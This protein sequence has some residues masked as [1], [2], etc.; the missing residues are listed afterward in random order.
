MVL[1]K[2]TDPIPDISPG[3]SE[4]LRKIK[5]ACT[6]TCFL[7]VLLRKLPVLCSFWNNQTQQ[8][9]DSDFLFPQKEPGTASSLLQKDFKNQNKWLLRKLIPTQHCLEH[10][11]PMTPLLTPDPKPGTQDPWLL[12]QKTNWPAQLCSHWHYW[13]CGWGRETQRER[14]TDNFFGKCELINRETVCS[15]L[16]PNEKEPTLFLVLQKIRQPGLRNLHNWDPAL[17]AVTL[18]KKRKQKKILRRKSHYCIAQ[19]PKG[20]GE[21][22]FLL[23]YLCAENHS[24]YYGLN[25]SSYLD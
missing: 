20:E 12:P 18:S 13:P 3:F 2:L 21:I 1:K 23:P 8:F 11:D 14:A 24:Y 6:T 17:R 7:A 10:L 19:S 9:F 22:N 25:P 16:Q 15:L 4:N 5:F